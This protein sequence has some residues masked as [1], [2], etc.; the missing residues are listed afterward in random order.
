MVL[1]FVPTCVALPKTEGEAGEDAS[2]ATSHVL[3]VSDGVGSW[4][5]THGI[6]SGAYARG[7]CRRIEECGAVDPLEAMWAAY[8]AV[9][10][11]DGSATLCVAMLFGSRL[12]VANIG[13]SRYMVLRD[14]KIIATSRPQQ[15]KFNAPYQ[16]GRGSPFSPNSAELTDIT[17][18]PGDRVV[19]AT[20]GLWDN[21]HDEVILEILRDGGGAAEL[22]ARAR[23]ISEDPTALTPFAAN[24]RALDIYDLDGGKPDDITVIVAEVVVAVTARENATTRAA[25]ARA[26]A[27]AE[28]RAAE[29]RAAEARAAEARAAEA[30]ARARAKARTEA[31]RL[32][33]RFTIRPF[34]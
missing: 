8:R 4:R 2:L 13:D 28:E 33:R 18:A 31:R 29:E 9:P 19:L 22:V 17:L 15:F 20:D 21:L 3:C 34:W 25:E 26:E 23:T 32:R 27:R 5:H 12:E 1:C 14:G 7:L 24:A 30:R 10:K 6:D 16:L 11:V